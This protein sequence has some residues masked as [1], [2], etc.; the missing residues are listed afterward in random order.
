MKQPLLLNAEYLESED[1]E[2]EKMD[3]VAMMTSPR[4]RKLSNASNGD[5]KKRRTTNVMKSTK[6]DKTTEDKVML[7]G[8]QREI[9]EK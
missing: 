9:E 2:E 6:P 3:I 5:G 1:V 4:T 8:A 7:I